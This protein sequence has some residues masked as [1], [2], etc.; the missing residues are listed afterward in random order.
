MKPI[1]KTQSLEIVARVADY[2]QDLVS[3]VVFVGG[4]S[5]AFQITD[6]NIVTVRPT[7]DVDLIVEV[8]NLP[9]YYRFEKRLRKLG[10]ESDKDGPRCRFLVEG[11]TVDV[12]PDNEEILGFSNR[13][14]GTAIDTADTHSVG[15]HSIRVVSPPLFLA[16]KLEAHH[17]RSDGDYMGSHDLEDV[18]AVVDGRP[19]LIRDC[20]DAPADVRGYLHEEFAT[21]LADDEF[22]NVLPRFVDP[23]G[24]NARAHVVRERIQSLVKTLA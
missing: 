24:G 5:A 10:F 16:T 22:L 13:W 20:L 12:M 21:L 4:S 8:M 6:K 7:L 23:A 14:Y 9:D 19:T 3:E 18:L 17:G 11:I 15:D 2:L 1:P